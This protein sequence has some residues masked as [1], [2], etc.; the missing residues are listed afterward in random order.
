MK[1]GPIIYSL[2]TLRTLTC[3]Q[4]KTPKAC[5]SHRLPCFDWLIYL[6]ESQTEPSS[7]AVSNMTSQ[8]TDV[9]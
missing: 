2:M 1:S 5:R 4:L 6:S 7:D 9:A 8:S 3:G